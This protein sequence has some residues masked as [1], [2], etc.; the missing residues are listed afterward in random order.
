MFEKLTYYMDNGFK[1]VMHR[2]CSMKIVTA[3]VIVN[4]GSMNETENDNGI[5]H[6]VEHI[7]A[8]DNQDGSCISINMEKLRNSGAIYNAHT[9]KENTSF[10][11]YGMSDN[12]KLYL[13]LLANLVFRHRDFKDEVFENEKK[14]VERELVSYYSS[15]NQISG[16]AAQALYSDAGVGRIIVGRRQNISNFTQE[17]VLDK[18]S[19]V[20]V[21]E[22]TSIVLYGDFQYEYAKDLIESYFGNIKDSPAKISVE[23]V[24]ISPGYYFNSNFN[25]ENSILSLCYRKITNENRNKI[26]N[27]VELLLKVMLDPVLFRRM[28]YD[29]RIKHGLSYN[30]G[31]FGSFT[32]QFLALGV[33]SI[34]ESKKLVEVFQIMQES[35]NTL[36]ENGLTLTEL[37]KAKR[38][39]ITSRIYRHSDVKEQSF[40]LLKRANSS[41]SFSPDNEIREIN[42][43][44]LDEVNYIL[45]D[46]LSPT[47]LGFACIG[48]CDFDA[49]IEKYMV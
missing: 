49:I 3:G 22:N 26:A 21:P 31:G 40:Q 9:D 19:E 45:N 48:N 11:I 4:F 39:S 37:E 15:F 33:T 8:S 2:D 5:A 36:R 18:I 38:N 1:V 28:G 34:F 6:F 14:V 16:R 12:L 30:M 41:D 43:L 25:G 42:N 29:L 23:P 13:E 32:G 27:S 7:L 35:L 10:Y 44:Q 20:Y 24:R 46:L 47:N 17:T